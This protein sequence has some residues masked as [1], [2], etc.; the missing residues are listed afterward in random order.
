M[1]PRWE[2]TLPDIKTYALQKHSSKSNVVVAGQTGRWM[3]VEPQTEA[4]YKWKLNTGE[5]GHPKPCESTD[6]L[7]DGV[8]EIGSQYEEIN[9]YGSSGGLKLFPKDMSTQN[10]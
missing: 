8:G 5:K 10:L 7:A 2:L 9:T 3:S 6:S 4:G 1:E